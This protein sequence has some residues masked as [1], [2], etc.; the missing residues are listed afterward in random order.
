MTPA[1]ETV[2]SNTPVKSQKTEGQRLFTSFE[3]T[4]RMSAYLLAFVFGEMGYTEAKTKDGV[5]IRAY[6]TPDNVALTEHGLDVTVRGLEFFCDYFEM[7]FPLPKLDIVALPDFSV[8]AMENWG[9]MTFRE[10]AML[11][12]PKTSSIESRQIVALVVCHELTHQWFGDLVTMKWWDDLWL[13]ESFANMMEYRAVD[14]L[15]PEWNIWE[16]FVSHETASAKR[17]DSLADVQA[18]QCDVNHPD[19]ISSIFDPSIVYAKG[20]TVLYMLMNYVGEEVFRAGLKL[21]FAK[22]AYGNTRAADLWAT[23][24]EAGGQDISGFMNDWLQRPGFPLV[25]VDWKPGDTDLKLEQRRFFSDPASKPQ[26]K[27]IISPGRCRWR[28]LTNLVQ[29]Y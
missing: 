5:L 10:T 9:L 26:K 19:E 23:L 20:G 18:I 14:A 16:Q 8:G 21:Y 7:P 17:R 29:I 3:T 24:A 27:P 1:G 13:N 4:P 28:L 15:Y 12:D 22:H 6:A 2:I 11:A 25:D